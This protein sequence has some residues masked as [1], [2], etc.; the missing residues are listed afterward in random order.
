LGIFVGA[1]LASV[2]TVMIGKLGWRDT[3]FIVGCVG[4]VFAFIAM[5]FVRDPVRGRFDPKKPAP[6]PYSPM[7]D[8]EEIV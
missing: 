2:T 8:G 4:I 7:D 3:Y 1:G 5:V 6:E